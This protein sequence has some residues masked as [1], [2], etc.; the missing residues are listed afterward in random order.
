MYPEQAASLEYGVPSVAYDLRF[1]S[2]NHKF[3]DKIRPIIWT[4]SLYFFDN[5]MAILFLL[6]VG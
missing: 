1:D 3:A 6:A 5:F 2:R 4:V